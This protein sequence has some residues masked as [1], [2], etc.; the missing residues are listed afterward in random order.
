MFN[1]KIDSE[2]IAPWKK[3]FFVLVP[4]RDKHGHFT[5]SYNIKF[6]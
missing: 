1:L 4:K 6:S 3:G 2:K 5:N